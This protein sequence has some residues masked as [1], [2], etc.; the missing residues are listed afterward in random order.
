MV[1]V[2][3]SPC[4]DVVVAT[5][6]TEETTPGVVV[7]SG[8]VM[9][10]ASPALTSDWSEASSGMVPIGS[11][12]VAV[13]TGP[14]ARFPRFAVTWLTR[15]ARGSNTTCL[16]DSVAATGVVADRSC[17][18]TS[19][20]AVAGI[21][22]R[23]DP[24]EAAGENAPASHDGT[25]PAAAIT[26]IPKATQPPRRRACLTCE[27]R[28]AARNRLVLGNRSAHGPSPAIHPAAVFG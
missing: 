22:C 16:S 19:F 21:P 8:S 11:S 23:P 20:V 12:D 9:V 18:V 2:G 4:P 17:R 15:S 6:P 28:L 7:P 1:V 13:S 10:T 14:D 25:T 27:V 26:M 24:D 5:L 3:F